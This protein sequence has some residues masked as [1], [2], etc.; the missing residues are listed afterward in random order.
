M[1]KCIKCQKYYGLSENGNECSK[2]CKNLKLAPIYPKNDDQI[3]SS[4]ILDFLKTENY[5]PMPEK[6]FKLVKMLIGNNLLICNNLLI[7]NNML[8]TINKF[9]SK[10]SKIY[11]FTDKQA[12]ELIGNQGYNYTLSHEIVRNKL[13][14]WTDHQSGLF[15]GSSFCYHGNFG[16][17]PKYRSTIKRLIKNN[18][19]LI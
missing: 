17:V 16:E 9:R 5:I 6:Y 19:N 1:S 7:G 8:N 12:R 14:P 10:D 3:E 4:E 11:L 2:C 18:I 13:M 15:H